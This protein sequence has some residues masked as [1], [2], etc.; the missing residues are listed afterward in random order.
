MVAGGDCRARGMLL[1]FLLVCVIVFPPTPYSKFVS[2]GNDLEE[3]RTMLIQEKRRCQVLESGRG[4]GVRV[5]VESLVSEEAEVVA[6]AIGGKAKGDACAAVFLV[7]TS[8]ELGRTQRPLVWEFLKDSDSIS[9]TY[10]PL[11]VFKT[12]STSYLTLPSKRGP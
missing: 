9:A 6:M 2:N 7:K 10:L 4:V 3:R 1:F 12:T 11:V 5:P 8:E